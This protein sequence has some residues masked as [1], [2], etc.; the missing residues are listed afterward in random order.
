MRIDFINFQI[1]GRTA[2][3]V[4]ESDATFLTALAIGITNTDD[5]VQV[6]RLQIVKNVKTTI[7]IYFPYRL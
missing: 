4:N 1:Q 5:I 3:L 6:H 2:K 7:A